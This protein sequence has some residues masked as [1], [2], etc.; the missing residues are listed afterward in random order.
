MPSDTAPAEIADNAPD[1]TDTNSTTESESADWRSSL[2]EEIRDNPSFSKFKDVDSLAASY[3]NLQSH[4]GRD[5]ITKPVTESDWDDVYEFL[6][7][8]EGPEKY[9]VTLSD[10]LPEIVANQFNDEALSSFKQEAHK[11]GLNSAQVSS[12]VSWQAN[13]MVGQHKA[14]EDSMAQSIDTGETALREEWGR[15]YDQNLEFA[16]KAF[17]EYGGDELAAKMESSGMGNDPD[18]LKAFANIAKTTMADKDLAGT[19]NNAKMAMTP[20][21]AKSEAA[22]IMGHPAYT[23]KRHP[24]HVSIVKKVQDLFNQAYVD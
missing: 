20:E 23:D 19:S 9:E 10:D 3:V 11:L 21:E 22:A 13:N 17:N 18:V 15:A 7:R 5:K 12:L 14:M 6:G 2:P 16:K 8:P 1:V 24:E 4:L